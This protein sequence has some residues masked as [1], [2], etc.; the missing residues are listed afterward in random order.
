MRPFY[1]NYLRCGGGVLGIVLAAVTR[2][3]LLDES[4]LYPFIGI[5]ISVALFVGLIELYWLWQRQQYRDFIFEPLQ[6]GELSA[7]AA[8]QW[9]EVTEQFQLLGFRIVGDYV[10]DRVVPATMAR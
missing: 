7:K 3:R 5:Y 4:I 10:V 6:P 8:A 1:W 9:E 2:R